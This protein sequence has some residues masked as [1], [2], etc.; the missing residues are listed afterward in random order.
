MTEPRRRADS[1]RTGRVPPGPVEFSEVE[2]LAA[3]WEARH[4][5][6]ASGRRV[7][8]LGVQQYLAHERCTEACSAA[9]HPHHRPP[10]HDDAEKSSAGGRPRPGARRA[11]A[12]VDAKP[13]LSDLWGWLGGGG[14]GSGR[15]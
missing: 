7:G 10:A 13:H 3:Q 9:G 11:A 4:A 6:A 2:K 5:V 14:P 12:P 8:G 15:A 1:P